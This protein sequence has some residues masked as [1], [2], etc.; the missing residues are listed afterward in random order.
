MAGNDTTEDLRTRVAWLYY[1]EG[2]T[3]DEVAQ[4]VGLT[5]ARVLR[6]LA[7][8]R[9]DGTVQ[10]RVTT[11]LSHC[12]ELERRLEEKWGL[13]RAVVIPD[14]QDQSQIPKLIGQELGAMLSR[15]VRPD[16][17]IGLGWGQTLTN[18]VPSIEPRE[19]SGI[20]IIS[21]LGGL[22]RV[23]KVNPSEFAWRVADRLAA[24]CY[25]MA[26]PVYAPTPEI[27][28]A[29]LDHS[30]IAEIF[31]RARRLDLAILSL[32]DLTPHSIFVQYGLLTT[33]EIASLEQAGAVGDV[34]CH[35]VDA[36][37]EVVD[38]PVNRRVLAVDPRELRSARRMVLA[39]GGWQKFTII[40]AALRMLSPAV[41]ITD[42]TVAARLCA[43]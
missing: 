12:V 9:A 6:I 3:Q 37:G 17:S 40:R 11:K 22:T 4:A 35:F 25:L 19:A 32:G 31:E 14:P 23:E 15:E 18:G 42:E 29:L 27:R 38:H 30:G 16:S 13:E 39:S 28:D 5:R 36:E 10:I 26:A 43:S 2:M 20:K 8:A 7:N 33:E 34:L 24:E 41:L 1:A 21:L